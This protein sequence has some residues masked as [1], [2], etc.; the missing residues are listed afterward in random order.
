M[1]KFVLGVAIALALPAAATLV[2]SDRKESPEYMLWTQS[3]NA[4]AS[5]G[6]ALGG[7]YLY[8]R[9]FV[10]EAANV[11]IGTASGGG[12]GNTVI[13]VTNGTSN[14]LFTLP[15]ATSQSSGVYNTRTT[16]GFTVTGTCSFAAGATLSASVTTAGCTT[17]QPYVIHIDVLGRWL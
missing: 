12:A 16:A 6:G 7:R 13:T 4:V 9:G 8:G 15:C 10:V 3:R 2:T 5:N 1:R 17:T 11:A 14:C